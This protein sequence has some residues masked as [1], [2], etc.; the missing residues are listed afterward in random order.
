MGSMDDDL[1]RMFEDEKKLEEVR[2]VL[3]ENL[4]AVIALAGHDVSRPL[5]NPMLISI[6]AACAT[7]VAVP[8]IPPKDRKD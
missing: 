5:N 4:P 2:A 7:I 6:A 1:R 8:L 3:R